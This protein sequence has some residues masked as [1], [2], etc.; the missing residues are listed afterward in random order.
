MESDVASLGVGFDAFRQQAI[1]REGLVIAARHQAFDDVAADLLNR[2]PFTMKGL[3][4]SKVPSRPK[5]IRP[6]FGAPG[7][8]IGHAGE[9]R[10]QRRGAVHRDAGAGSSGW[11]GS[12][13]GGGAAAAAA[14]CAQPSNALSQRDVTFDSADLTLKF[15]TTL[16]IDGWTRKYRLLALIFSPAVVLK[17][18]TSRRAARSVT[19]PPYL[20]PRQPP[21]KQAIAPRGTGR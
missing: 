18:G 1:E 20:A 11:A 21:N 17:A 8:A 9:P 10:R 19:Y 13:R 15:T 4:L 6:P 16:D 5:M 14:S 2:D 7:L 12:G 3:R